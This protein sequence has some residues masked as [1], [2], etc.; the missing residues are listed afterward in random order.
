VGLCEP[1][2]AVGAFDR[3]CDRGET[4]LRIYEPIRLVCDA[5]RGCRGLL[6]RR[7]LRKV[8][9]WFGIACEACVKVQSGLLSWTTVPAK[10]TLRIFYRDW[11]IE[12]T[13][14]LARAK[15]GSVMSRG[16]ESVME[17]FALLW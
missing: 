1:G 8:E 13:A 4:G 5:C 2:M 14:L 6:S 15:K 16:L 7:D 3:I 10:D 17:R 9:E 11:H 12:M